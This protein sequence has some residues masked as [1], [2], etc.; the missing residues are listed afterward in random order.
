MAVRAADL[1]RPLLLHTK[2]K[3]LCFVTQCCSISRYSD[4]AGNTMAQH[5]LAGTVATCSSS[6]SLP[7]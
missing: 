4:C 6:S 3:L 1:D 5:N 2:E 7:R